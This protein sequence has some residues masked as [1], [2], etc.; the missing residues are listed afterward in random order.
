MKKLG[1]WAIA[2]TVVG[3]SAVL[4]FAL[5]FALQG[6]PFDR[7]ERTLRAS[8]PDV[9][10]IQA[11]SL[12]K[13]AGAIAG[14]VHSVRMLTPEE[15]AASTQPENVIELVL[16]IDN[17]VPALSEGLVASVASDT[18]LS[19]KFI[20]LLGGDPKAPALKNNAVIA[21][22]TPVTFDAILRDL[23]GVLAKLRQL[24]GGG[25][26][27]N[28][29]DGIMPK[30]DKL[31]TDLGDTVAKANGLIGSGDGLIDN[32]NGLVNHGNGLIK[33]ADGLVNDG[34]TLIDANKDA[35]SKAVVQ[36]G[37]TAGS[38]DD[39]ARRLDQ[40]VKKNEGSVQAIL[41]DAKVTL[42]ELKSAAITARQLAEQLR[43][44]PQSLLWGPGRPPKKAP[45]SDGN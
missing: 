16:A 19:D 14:T 34:R 40:L 37:A 39:L 29:L 27:G 25:D 36:L 1:D 17:K 32:A 15:R 33:N 10:G 12:V 5:V 18:L 35:I 42:S 38:L 3:C 43:A 11:S 45:A 26:G 22:I 4:F 23:S 2:L 31:L 44:R 9:T 21:S 7:P 13:Y 30:V 8:F 41:G 20:V 24:V 6:N 28:P